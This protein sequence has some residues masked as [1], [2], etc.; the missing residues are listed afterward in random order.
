MALPSPFP[1]NIV[2][3]E[4]ISA[5]TD[6]DVLCSLWVFMVDVHRM[7]NFTTQKTNTSNI[8]TQDTNNQNTNRGKT[9]QPGNKNKQVMLMQSK[10]KH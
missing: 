5:I 4:S 1:T 8:Q 10:I 3:L 2:L 7:E 6:F 9:R